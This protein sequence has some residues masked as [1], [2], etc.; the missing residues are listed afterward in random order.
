MK[1]KS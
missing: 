1:K